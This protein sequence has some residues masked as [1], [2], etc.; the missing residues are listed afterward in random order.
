VNSEINV[1]SIDLSSNIISNFVLH[2]AR[3]SLIV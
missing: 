2:T 3:F 1:K